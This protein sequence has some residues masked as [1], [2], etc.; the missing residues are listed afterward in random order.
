[1][2]AA[3]LIC[4]TPTLWACYPA[5]PALTCPERVENGWVTTSYDFSFSICGD[6]AVDMLVVVDNAADMAPYQDRIGPFVETLTRAIMD[7][8]TDLAMRSDN[9]EN[10]RVAVVTGDMEEG[11][12]FL[13]AELWTLEPEDIPAAA[14]GLAEVGTDGDP[15]QQPLAASLA[16][17]NEFSGNYFMSFLVVLVISAR[18]DASQQDPPE[19]NLLSPDEYTEMLMDER[20]RLFGTTGAPGSILFAALT[21]VPDV[22]ACQGDGWH[23]ASEGCLDRSDMAGRRYVEVATG[24]GSLGFVHSIHRDDWTSI[25]GD[26]AAVVHEFV[27]RGCAYRNLQWDESRSA[28]PCESIFSFWGTRCPEGF[29]W[30]SEL[31]VGD[32][33]NP[34][35]RCAM[36]PL[37]VP[38]D[39]RDL[40]E[41][42]VRELMRTGDGWFYC[43]RPGENFSDACRDRMDNDLDGLVDCDDDECADCM[44]CRED[45]AVDLENCPA[46]CR[47]EI[48][49]TSS[50][51]AAVNDS[52]WEGLHCPQPV[53]I[54]DPNCMET[55]YSA[56]N[57][58]RDNN[59]NGA[60]DCHTVRHGEATDEFPAHLPDPDCCPMEGA[61]GAPCDLDP[62]G[63]G[64]ADWTANCDGNDLPDACRAAAWARGCL[65][66]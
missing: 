38:R 36:E 6:P 66:D 51:M 57:D 34:R 58:G 39:C 27:G 60:H 31:A 10:I 49:Y 35:V 18:D 52:W 21:D 14:A 65:L 11:E 37:A 15:I 41:E 17:L 40:S 26:L 1:M 47:Q 9:I 45:F 59:G 7:V 28:L 8:D 54:Q 16:G 63:D 24:L 20:A 48:R 22:P 29:P 61:E 44:N 33:E 23:L 19:T 30:S 2:A 42:D 62:D 5:E 55:G 53:D 13:E 50:A 43:E 32:E 3:M 46:D 64:V 25:A 12:S 4:L 56:C